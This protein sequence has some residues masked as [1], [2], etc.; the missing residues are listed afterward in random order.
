MPLPAPHPAGTRVDMIFQLSLRR[1][2]AG[3]PA[4]GS[5]QLEATLRLRLGTELPV[6]VRLWLQGKLFHGRPYSGQSPTGPFS[7]RA[8]AYIDGPPAGNTEI[9]TQAAGGRI[10]RV[11]PSA[12]TVGQTTR[13]AGQAGAAAGP[14]CRGPGPPIVSHRGRDS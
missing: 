14:R 3:G 9:G 1:A 4:S 8:P 11:R 7:D 6:P 13:W 12:R 2:G 10:V 5:V